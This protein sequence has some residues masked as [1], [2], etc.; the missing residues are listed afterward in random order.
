MES[1][2]I[3]NKIISSNSRPFL[4]AEA[5][6]NHN[7]S[8]EK[9]FKMIEAAKKGNADAIK[10]QTFKTEEFISDKKQAY[11]YVSKGK[12]VTETWYDLYKRYEWKEDVWQKLKK[13]CDQ[14]KIIFMSTPSSVFDLN[15][16]L[17]LG[18]SAIKVGSDDFTN[19]PLIKKF[20]E[21]KLPI[22][23]SCGMSN[24]EEIDLTLKESGALNGYPI[25]LMLC[26]SQYPTPAPDVN[27]KRLD[28]LRKKDPNLI[29]GFSDHTIGTVASSTAVAFGA[30]C[31][32]KHF[33]LDRNDE[34]P[35]HSFSEDP[36]G[37]KNW[38]DSI[39][40]SYIMMGNSSL[41]PT[42]NEEKMKVL[43]RKSVV[44]IKDIQ[45][46]EEINSKNI[47]VKRPGDGLA[48]INFYKIIGKKAKVFIGKDQKIKMEFLTN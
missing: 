39:H 23:L 5:S 15:I 20:C 38:A 9:A 27:L 30:R 33:T 36:E 2:K 16:L 8:L 42:E 32:E 46:G 29:L 22:V 10:F 25:M 18:V 28:T 14:E 37:L 21:S 19:I 34:G 17:K 12:K 11:T 41:R 47:G 44:A 31:F 7:G 35:D 1:I 24:S 4:I 13:K 6:V 48:P 3:E 45:K 43:L 40:L 26:V